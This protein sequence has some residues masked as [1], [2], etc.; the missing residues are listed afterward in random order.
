MDTFESHLSEILPASLQEQ[1]AQFQAERGIPSMQEAVVR[2]FQ[3]YFGQGMVSD[4]ETRFTA[5]EADIASLNDQMTAIR[6][7]I[8]IIATR[9]DLMVDYTPEADTEVD[10]I[11]N[12]PS[13]EESIQD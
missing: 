7:A 2:V 3:D 8:A 10:P 12:P 4:P 6:Q 5:L 11:L 9:V 1:L 13:T